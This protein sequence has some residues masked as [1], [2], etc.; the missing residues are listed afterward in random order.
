M[1]SAGDLSRAE[2]DPRQAALHEPAGLL[3]GQSPNPLRLRTS[4]TTDAI[5]A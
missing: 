4:L 3:R 1:T 2:T 5:G